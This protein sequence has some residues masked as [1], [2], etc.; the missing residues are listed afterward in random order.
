MPSLLEMA[1]LLAVAVVYVARPDTASGGA[2]PPLKI[3][4][5]SRTLRRR[6]SDSP[7]CTPECPAEALLRT[8]QVIVPASRTLRRRS[9]DSPPCTLECPAEALLRTFKVI[10]LDSRTLQ[11][12]PQFRPNLLRPRAPLALAQ[13]SRLLLPCVMALRFRV[14]PTQTP[15]EQVR[16]RCHLL[17]LRDGSTTV[18]HRYPC[19]RHY[20]TDAPL[21]LQLTPTHRYL[22]LD[23]YCDRATPLSPLSLPPRTEMT[24]QPGRQFRGVETL[25]QAT[26][27]YGCSVPLA[28]APPTD[29]LPRA[30]VPLGSVQAWSACLTFMNTLSMTAVV[31]Q[32]PK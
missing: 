7:P 4:P 19:L 25:V 13:P 1:A 15:A 17:L 18:P 20:P 3:V 23:R 26:R 31:M 8:F 12:S 28:I 11:T 30:W 14:T 16:S 22:I 21:L 5:D 27:T 24:H 2:L 6:S 9:P 29:M 10:V 32:T